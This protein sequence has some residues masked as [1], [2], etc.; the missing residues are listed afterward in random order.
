MSWPGR[1]KV[2][3]S[4]ADPIH[5][6]I[7]AASKERSLEDVRSSLSDLVRNF[8]ADTS[9]NRRLIRDLLDNDRALFYSSSIEIL[10]ESTDSRGGAPTED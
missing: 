1:V 8:E 3:R 2:F 9:G 4:P 5:V 6:P 10:K 7:Y